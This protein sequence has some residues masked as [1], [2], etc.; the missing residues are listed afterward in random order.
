MKTL[1]VVAFLV[2]LQSPGVHAEKQG[3]INTGDSKVSRYIDV[4]RVDPVVLANSLAATNSFL[5]ALYTRG[6]RA[7][8]QEF[9]KLGKDYV[10]KDDWFAAIEDAL[11]KNGARVSSEFVSASR[12]EDLGT[13]GKGNYIIIALRSTYE[14]RVLVETVALSM[15]KRRWRV[16]SYSFQQVRDKSTVTTKEP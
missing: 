15:E 4:E 13:V 7:A 3:M 8:W 2:L 1:L 6:S 11:R 12:T 9:S 10:D 5:D 14:N 16:G